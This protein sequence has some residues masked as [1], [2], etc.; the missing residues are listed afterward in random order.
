MKRGVASRVCGIRLR[1]LPLRRIER[2]H[3]R[4]P[5]FRA[6]DGFAGVVR[7][8]IWPRGSGG[9]FTVRRVAVGSGDIEAVFAE[10][11]EVELNSFAHRFLDFL[12]GCARGNAAG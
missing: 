9:E 10:A 11:V 3:F 7:A 4:F 6:E 5:A 1:A 12:A 2:N 8:M